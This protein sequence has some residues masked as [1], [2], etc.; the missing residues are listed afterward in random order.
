[1]LGDWY[2]QGSALVWDANG[3]VLQTLPR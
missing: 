1:V 2:T 3:Y